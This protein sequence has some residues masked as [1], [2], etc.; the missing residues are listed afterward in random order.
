MKTVQIKVVNLDQEDF[1]W[2]DRI[3]STIYINIR[4]HDNKVSILQTL[5]HELV[6]ARLQ[7]MFVPYDTDQREYEAHL[8]SELYLM[9]ELDVAPDRTYSI[10]YKGDPKEIEIKYKKFTAMY[11][12]K[13]IL[14]LYLAVYNKIQKQAT[15]R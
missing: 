6:H 7:T 3:E 10:F 2:Y 13:K 5:I 8:I 14:K 15:R 11:N 4:H 9:N 12:I 1:G